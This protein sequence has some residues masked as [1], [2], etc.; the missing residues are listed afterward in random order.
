[1]K[2]LL[3]LLVISPACFAVEPSSERQIELRNLLKND[4]GACHG[5]LLQGGLGSPLQPQDLAQKSDEF[6]IDTITNGRKGSA[7]P[8]WKPF[9]T[10]DEIM[11]LIN[12]L[13]HPN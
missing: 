5:L 3:F 6:L 12:L 4:C 8:P 2:K 10:Q 7:M 9:M 13:R 11:W 1:M